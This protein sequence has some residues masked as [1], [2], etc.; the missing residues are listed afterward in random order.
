MSYSYEPTP[1]ENYAPMATAIAQQM[2]GKLL[3]KVGSVQCDTSP[4]LCP[5]ETLWEGQFKGISSLV[6]PTYEPMYQRDMRAWQTDLNSAQYERAIQCGAE[7]NPYEHMEGRQMFMQ[8]SAN[9]MAFS[10]DPYMRQVSSLEASKLVQP[11]LPC[12]RW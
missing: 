9:E 10:R 3:S 11:Q 8:F 2:K 1:G 12:A 7:W 5:F 6:I 4:P